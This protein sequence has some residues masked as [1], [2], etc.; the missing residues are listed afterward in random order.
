MIWE[1][2]EHP[3]FGHIDVLQGRMSVATV[4]NDE[5]VKHTVVTVSVILPYG[6][7][8]QGKRE[9]ELLMGRIME[10]ERKRR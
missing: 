2:D 1:E 5:T 3:E 9:A 7:V 4:R 8:E 6:E 10:L